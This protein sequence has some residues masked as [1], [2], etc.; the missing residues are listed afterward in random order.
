MPSG[1]CQ[2]I[3]LLFVRN[4]AGEL[5]AGGIVAPKVET[6]VNLRF[7]G[8]FSERLETI[9]LDGK[10]VGEDSSR[11]RCGGSVF[12]RIGRTSRRGQARL[13]GR[14]DFARPGTVV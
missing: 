9:C 3:A 2:Y 8:L 7:A 10:E 12:R 1:L 4:W 5:H 14:I 11:C 6:R 13:Q